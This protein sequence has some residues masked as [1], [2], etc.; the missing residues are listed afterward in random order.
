M[1]DKATASGDVLGN[2]NPATGTGGRCRWRAVTSQSSLP[3]FWQA[4][5]TRET[6]ATSILN[7][8]YSGTGGS[9][10]RRTYRSW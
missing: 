5:T 1:D 7:V 3:H 2:E 9:G 8:R 4:G 10:P 6:V